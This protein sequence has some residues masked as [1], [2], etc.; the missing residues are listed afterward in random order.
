MTTATHPLLSPRLPWAKDDGTP[1]MVL[2]MRDAGDAVVALSRG[3]EP[4]GYDEYVQRIPGNYSKAPEY[5]DRL[6]A[7]AKRV[8]TA[9][10]DFGD[11]KTL[12]AQFQKI[13]DAIEAGRQAGIP[14]AV[15]A[16]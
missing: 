15:H 8:M 6:D 3:N 1:D 7:G 10:Q 11:M 14:A 2:V 4:Y 9:L 5:Y 12:V 16:R 13:S